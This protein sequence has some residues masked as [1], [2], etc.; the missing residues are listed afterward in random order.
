MRF[1]HSVVIQLGVD[2]AIQLASFGLW[3]QPELLQEALW[4]S[5]IESV[6]LHRSLLLLRLKMGLMCLGPKTIHLGDLKDR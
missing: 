6:A 1:I 4:T 2:S 3:V 5:W